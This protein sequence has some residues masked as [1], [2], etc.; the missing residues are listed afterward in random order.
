MKNKRELVVLLLAI[1]LGFTP[2]VLCI[3]ARFILGA[4]VP[5]WA[6]ILS[7]LTLPGKIHYRDD[8]EEPGG[9]SLERCLS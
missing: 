8:S 9:T 4:D 5:W 7:L 3:I 1:T 2:I 6:F